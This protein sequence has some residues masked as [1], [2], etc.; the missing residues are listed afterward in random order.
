MENLVV[1]RIDCTLYFVLEQ[2]N[3]NKNLK[4][5]PSLTNAAV[6]HLVLVLLQH[7]EHSFDFLN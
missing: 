5:Y 7:E 4:M 2:P 1:G 6:D 3:M